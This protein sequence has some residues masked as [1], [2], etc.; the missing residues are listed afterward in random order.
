MQLR[1]MWRAALPLIRRRATLVC[2]GFVAI[3]IAVMPLVAGAA[4]DSRGTQSAM[5]TEVWAVSI[6]RVQISQVHRSL[7][8]RLHGNGINTLIVE[9]GGLTRRQLRRIRRDG[10]AASLSVLTPIVSRKLRLFGPPGVASALCKAQKAR[11]PDRLCSVAGSLATAKRLA[12]EP[13]VDAVVAGVRGPR[14]A[15]YLRAIRGTARV[16]AVAR[17]AARADVPAWLYAMKTAHGNPALDLG[18][19][20]AAFRA[21]RQLDW[22]FALLRSVLEGAPPPPTSADYYVAARGSDANPGTRARPFATFDKCY[23]VA[24]PGDVCAFSGNFKAV[25]TI[26][27]DPTKT[28]PED[29]V[30]RPVP[31]SVPKSKGLK[32]FGDHVTVYGPFETG[33]ISIGSASH[34]DRAEDVT[35]DGRSWNGCHAHF[36]L[37]FDGAKNATYRNCFSDGRGVVGSI[38][39]RPAPKNG[40]TN[41]N[42]TYDRIHFYGPRNPSHAADCLHPYNDGTDSLT[43]TNSWFQWC[44]SYG[45]LFNDTT[46]R[47]TVCADQPASLIENNRFSAL[48]NNAIDTLNPGTHHFWNVTIQFNSMLD[49]ITLGK[50]TAGSYCNLT[51]RGNARRVT[52]GVSCELPSGVTAEYNVT[53]RTSRGRGCAYSG[54]GNTYAG[55]VASLSKIFADNVSGDFRLPLGS[56]LVGAAN[57]ARIFPRDDYRDRPRPQGLLDAGAA[58]RP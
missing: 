21:A 19:A 45:I 2:L 28:S 16:V 5:P 33:N 1:A 3:A 12:Q 24:S 31:G 57:G 23:H 56:P 41:S 47:Y 55:S 7:L 38:A 36:K 44:E 27:H 11:H 34:S 37:N 6:S 30:F 15:R 17:F 35:V 40:W 13:N 46:D 52:S 29:V 22:Y 14:D 20:P 32:I 10:K 48:G 50:P 49:G 58:E 26:K 39:S 25:W 53:Y 9:S 42:I 54:V 43:V 18:I 4:V 51:L 8:R